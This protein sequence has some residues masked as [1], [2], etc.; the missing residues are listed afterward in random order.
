MKDLEEIIICCWGTSPPNN[1]CEEEAKLL[2]SCVN[3]FCLAHLKTHIQLDS[4]IWQVSEIWQCCCS[5][6]QSSVFPAVSNHLQ[7]QSNG[8]LSV[9][10]VCLSVGWFA[11]LH[12]NYWTEFYTTWVKDGSRSRMDNN[13]FWMIILLYTICCSKNVWLVT[14]R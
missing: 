9:C 14:D 8:L 1:R 11:G 5:G 13:G 3:I 10:V 7:H 2:S 6:L 4:L 12:K